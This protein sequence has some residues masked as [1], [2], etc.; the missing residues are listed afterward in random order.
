MIYYFIPDYDKPSWGIGMLYYHVHLLNKNG[1]DATVLH[2][3]TPFKLGW[4]NMDVPVAYMDQSAFVPLRNDILVIPEIVAGDKKLLTIPGR[5]IVFVQGSFLI[6]LHLEKA[7]TYRELGYEHAFTYLPHLHEILGRHFGIDT[8][9]IP[10]FVAP[11]FYLDPVKSPASK[12]KKQVILFPKLGSYDY[13]IDYD[14][15]TKMLHRKLDK[16]VN[17]KLVDK[18]F[19]RNGNWKIIELENKSHKEVAGL[20]Q[21]SAFFVSINTREAFNSSVPEAMAG[22]CI[23]VC[24]E[25]YGPKDF[26]QN[27][28]NAFVF[29]NNYA[30]PLIDR[31]FALIDNYSNIQNELAIIRANAYQTASA[32]TVENTE[33]ALIR[34]FN[35]F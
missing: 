24:Y 19:R 4:L 33:V 22:G 35:N 6:L 2:E 31:L 25:A 14:I 18:I 27:K 28:Q 17:T 1:F 30:Y 10:P 11:Y 20:M 23:V 7:Y 26:L 21:E 13:D 32:Y 9:D 34:F 12:R 16:N 8:T 15:I 5:K 3:Q 29:P